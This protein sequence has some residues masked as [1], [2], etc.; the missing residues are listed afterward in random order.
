MFAHAAWQDRYIS[1]GRSN[2]LL[3]LHDRSCCCFYTNAWAGMNYCR[4]WLVV[5]WDAANIYKHENKFCI[6]SWIIFWLFLISAIQWRILYL[7]EASAGHRYMEHMP[8]A[9]SG[10]M[11]PIPDALA[12][13]APTTIQL[14]HNGYSPQEGTIARARQLV[15]LSP[16]GYIHWYLWI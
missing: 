2:Q 8:V 15:Y 13:K 5:A 4:C 14:T 7:L 16:I 1:M 10:P 3:R 6:T 12:L 11:A 9:K